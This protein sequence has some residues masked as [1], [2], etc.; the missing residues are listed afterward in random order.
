MR[1]INISQLNKSIQNDTMSFI[2]KSN[3]DYTVKVA[4]V[5]KC[6]AENKKPIVLLSGPSG[7]GKTTTAYRLGDE[8]E[9]LGIKANIISM[10]N[11]FIPNKNI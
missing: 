5:A 10:D 11:Y 8:L 1:C 6:I 4:N 7:S 3:E 9:K 2:R